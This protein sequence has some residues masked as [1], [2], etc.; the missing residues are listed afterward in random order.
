MVAVWVIAAWAAG[1]AVPSA[2]TTSRDDPETLFRRGMTALHNFEYEEANEAFGLARQVDPGFALAYWGEAMTYHQTLWRR[3]NVD[4]ARQVLGLLGPTPAARA[5]KS[6]N[7]QSP[8]ACWP[9]STCY[10]AA[11]MSPAADRATRPPWAACTP[12]FP[13]T[14]ISRLCTDWH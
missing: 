6:S 9:L 10:S 5:A 13:K 8:E 11:V 7:A 3:E 1:A 2:Q 12:V 4:A 14:T